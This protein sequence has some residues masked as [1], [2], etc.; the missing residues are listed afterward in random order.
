M[1]NIQVQVVLL[2][3]IFI[4]DIFADAFA[5]SSIS[6][7]TTR[8]TGTTHGHSHGHVSQIHTPNRIHSILGSS[9]QV[10][11][12]VQ[13]TA[14]SKSVNGGGAAAA[15]G[16]IRP[17]HQNWWP[18]SLNS[19]LDPLRPNSVELLGE[20]VVLFYDDELM[21]WNCL[22]DRCPH[23][24]APLSE[25]RILRHHEHEHATNDNGDMNDGDAKSCSG[26]G[27]SLQCSYHGWEIDTK[28]ACIHVPQAPNTSTKVRD[29][30]S[31]PV[32]QAAGMIWVWSDPSTAG[33][34]ADLIP[35]PISPLVY[36]AYEQHGEMSCFM[37]DLP[38][39]M[40]LLG[41][42][43]LDLSH[44]P[45]SHHS[46]G[47]LDR[48]MGCELPLRMMSEQEKISYAEWETEIPALG[49]TIGDNSKNDSHKH[50]PTVPMYQ[51]EVVNSTQYDPIML[52]F[53]KAIKDGVAP[54]AN[55]T[56]SFFDPCHV[57][58]NRERKSG[59]RGG[60]E[61][62]MS[63]TNAGKSRVF[64][65][66]TRRTPPP[67][68]ASSTGE[69]TLQARLVKLSPMAL[70]KQ[71]MIS[72]LF[73][74]ASARGHLISHAIFD[75]DGIFLHKQG[76]RMRRSTLTYRDYSTPSSADVL[77]NAFRRYIDVA[78][79]KSKEAGRAS[80]AHAVSFQNGAAYSDDSPRSHLLDRYSSHTEHCSIC[81]TALE[82]CERQKR[83]F[84]TVRIALVGASGA[85]SFGLVSA[86]VARGVVVPPSLIRTMVVSTISS[87]GGAIGMTRA[88]KKV[89]KQIRAFR[90]EDYI[91]AEKH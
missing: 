83:I 69:P 81:A 79:R 58:Y 25:G 4:V 27:V 89:E 87:V 41:E 66:N 74:P 61:L 73:N 50:S 64:L 85:M 28:G 52:V 11:V 3:A 45:F 80:A 19:S 56:I 20:K 46:V 75:G 47:M 54:N 26:S 12:Q 17:L 34:L 48:S 22:A 55:S 36:E 42:N 91:H 60:V 31:Y 70:F 30:P 29:V 57:R 86:L 6:S 39:G 9:I 82:K 72:K 35:L 51:V 62:F 49:S 10:Q 59:N 5:F 71:Y 2:I 18:V 76:D 65:W 1:M 16:T 24:F 67:P 53:A 90:F 14:E 32:R 23:R 8:R 88:K 33:A 44:L 15:G 63:P 40:E 68:T 84:E 77:L 21:E 78:A 13:D 43:L 37:R 38:Y 7:A